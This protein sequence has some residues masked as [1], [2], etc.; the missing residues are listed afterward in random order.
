MVIVD[1]RI[2]TFLSVRVRNTTS[3][4]RLLVTHTDPRDVVHASAIGANMVITH[5][6]NIPVNDHQTRVRLP[7]RTT[8][9]LTSVARVIRTAVSRRFRRPRR[10]VVQTSALS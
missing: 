5:I 2:G 7:T 10:S 4:E 6:S 8:S 1:P 3:G 9:S